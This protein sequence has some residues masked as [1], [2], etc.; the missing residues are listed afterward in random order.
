MIQLQSIYRFCRDKCMKRAS[1]EFP[2]FQIVFVDHKITQEW[3][4]LR[5]RFICLCLFLKDCPNQLENLRVSRVLKKQRSP[6]RDLL[7]K[8][9][10]YLLYY[11]YNLLGRR[12]GKYG[13]SRRSRSPFR[14][15]LWCRQLF[16]LMILWFIGRWRRRF[17]RNL[18]NLK[19]LKNLKKLRR[20]RKLKK[21]R[22]KQSWLQMNSFLTF[23][24]PLSTWVVCIYSLTPSPCR[25]DLG[26][27]EQDELQ[28]HDS[29]S[30]QGHSC[31]ACWKGCFGR[32]QVCSGSCFYWL[33]PVLERRLPSSCPP[34]NCFLAW[35]GSNVKARVLLS[36]LLPANLL[37][38]PPAWSPSWPLPTTSPM[39]WLWEEPIERRKRPRLWRACPF[40]SP[41]LVACWITCRTPRGLTLRTFNAW[42]ST[43]PTVFFRLVLKKIW[44]P[45]WSCCQRRDKPCCS[46]LPKTRTSKDWPSFLY[47]YAMQCNAM[48]FDNYG[49]GEPGLCGCSRHVR[50]SDRWPFGTRIRGLL[51]CTTL[52]SPVHFLKEELQEEEDHVFALSFGSLL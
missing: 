24:L 52:P 29:H 34:L 20:K 30:S 38:R 48:Q 23:L 14:W 18:R 47:R 8:L 11:L 17:L 22:K 51:Q 42:W 19:N 46:P 36:S 35:S 1:R 15:C 16:K 2:V 50:R 41:R 5:V 45:S 32:C 40:S 12:S 4:L 6:W 28:D 27:L 13:W 25:A 31:P 44:R 21:R 49:I 33:G 3:L 9:P 39:V 7:E 26:S 37:F 10:K 43:R